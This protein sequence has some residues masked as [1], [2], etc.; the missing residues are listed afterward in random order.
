MRITY[1]LLGGQADA[2]RVQVLQEG[3]V[4]RIRKFT[5]FYNIILIVLQRR[6]KMLTPEGRKMSGPGF[7]AR[8]NNLPEE[9]VLVVVKEETTTMQR[10]NTHATHLHVLA[11]PLAS[12]AGQKS[13]NS[14]LLEEAANASLLWG[15][16]LCGHRWVPPTP[17]PQS[18]IYRNQVALFLKILSNFV[19]SPSVMG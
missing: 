16:R 5:H 1:C 8:A 9:R 10:G 18:S 2:V 19:S 3:S 12:S 7:W 4:N 15:S 14:G 11:W 17:C 13:A 6:A